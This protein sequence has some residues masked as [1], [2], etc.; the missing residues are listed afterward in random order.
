MFLLGARHFIFIGR[1]GVDKP[2]A[3]RLIKDLTSAGATIKVCR[4]SVADADVVQRAIHGASHAIGGVI[5]ASM[6]IHVS[7]FK[8]MDNS[9]W[10]ADW[11]R[12][13]KEPG[14]FTMLF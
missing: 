6:A 7:L 5:Q 11:S 2:S 4:G 3:A 9:A 1:S 12:R 8:D 14:I 10:H 13:F